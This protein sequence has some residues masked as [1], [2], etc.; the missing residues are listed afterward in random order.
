MQAYFYYYFRSNHFTY[1]KSIE[2]AKGGEKISIEMLRQLSA[3]VMKN[4][5][6]EYNTALG[7]FSSANGDL[8]LLNVSAGIGGRS[9]M[10]FSK[11]PMKLEEFCN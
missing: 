10:S 2:F 6:S 11:V 1:E 3:L 5:G 9:Y 8:R 4:T 7:S